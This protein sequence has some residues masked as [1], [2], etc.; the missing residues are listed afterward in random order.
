MKHIFLFAV[1]ALLLTGCLSRW[2]E[3]QTEVKDISVSVRGEQPEDET[4]SVFAGSY[5]SQ[6]PGA[7][8]LIVI[9]QN[10]CF[11]YQEDCNDQERFGDWRTWRIGRWTYEPERLNLGYQDG[12]KATA[13]LMNDTLIYEEYGNEVAFLPSAE[14]HVTVTKEP[15]W[16][17]SF[18]ESTE[19]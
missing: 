4:G 17:G 5:V 8:D 19:D 9:Y 14:V 15:S 18:N 13:T 12:G 2:E 11:Y 10:N 3:P 1:S 16:S 7:K 6:E